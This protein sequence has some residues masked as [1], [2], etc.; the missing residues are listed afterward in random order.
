MSSILTSR[1]IHGSLL[2]MDADPIDRLVGQWKKE[3]PDLDSTPMAVVGR[4]LRLSGL[5]QRSVEEVLRPFGLCLWQFDVLATLRRTGA[6]YQL[7]PTELMREVML[8]S[9]AMTNRIDRLETME[10]VERKPDPSDRRS[11]QIALTRKGK[12]L[13]DR[14]IAVRF[15]EASSVVARLTATERSSLE[16]S[17]KKLLMAVQLSN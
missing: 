11:V 4:V 13:V 10:L 16:Q 6:P 12:R 2:F 14:A 3:R 17:L 5:L 7:S 1:Y 15:D 8:S 9:G